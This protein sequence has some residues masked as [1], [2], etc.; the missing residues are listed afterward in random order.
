MKGEANW[1]WRRLDLDLLLSLIQDLS[2]LPV[3]MDMTRQQCWQGCPFER[4]N[5]LDRHRSFS[6]LRPSPG[7]GVVERRTGDWCV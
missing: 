4:G 5:R 2:Q 3:T 6:D 7:Q 1:I